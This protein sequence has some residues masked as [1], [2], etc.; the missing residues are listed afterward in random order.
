MF[1]SLPVRGALIQLQ[2]SWQRMQRDHDYAA[3][4]RGVLGE[5][6]AATGLIA[7]SLK[8]D[9]SVTLQISG[10][11]LL[12]M[13]V[14]Q[15][16]HELGMRGMASAAPDLGDAGYADLVTRS[17]CSVIVDSGNMEQPY[18]GIVEVQPESLAVSLENYFERSVQL[19]SRIVLLADERVSGGI[20]LQQM[21]D[22]GPTVD[23]DWYRLGLLAE[24]L[25]NDDFVGGVGLS[26]IHKLFNED[27][28]RVYRAR[29]VAFRC[30]CS[31]RRAAEVLRLLGADETRAACEERGQVDVTCEYCGRR[32]TF[33]TIDVSRLFAGL[34]VPGPGTLQ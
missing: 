9:G 28:I 30:R 27:D 16:T 5:A 26:L 31:R 17:R 18:Q 21:P 2:K 20:L 19:A 3:P 1:E 23:D 8:F 24:T 7:Q 34:T 12:N 22:R 11:G 6:A 14:M 29:R 15:C 25:R 33:D 10:E 13:L 32:Q 4:V